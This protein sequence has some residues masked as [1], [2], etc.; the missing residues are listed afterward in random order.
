MLLL[1]VPLNTNKYIKVMK[2]D[3][4]DTTDVPPPPTKRGT[5]HPRKVII[6]YN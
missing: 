6:I 2:P 3:A 4:E 5:G 1:L